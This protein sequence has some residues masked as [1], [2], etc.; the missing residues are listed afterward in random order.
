MGACKNVK[1]TAALVTGDVHALCDKLPPGNK[2]PNHEEKSE[3]RGREPE[4]TKTGAVRKKEPPPRRFQSKTACEKNTG[5]GPEDARK[6]DGNPQVVAAAQDDKGAGK[7]HEKH[8][9]GNDTDSDG[10]RVAFA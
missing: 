2:L 4:F 10:S 8:Q 1:K 3:D 5:V 9:N 7:G 6:T